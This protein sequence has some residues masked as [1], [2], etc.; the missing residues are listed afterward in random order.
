MSGLRTWQ[1]KRSR[2]LWFRQVR[3]PSVSLRHCDSPRLRVAG[4]ITG[5]RVLFLQHDPSKS[6][7]CAALR[8]G[9]TTIENSVSGSKHQ[10][11]FIAA[12][13]RNL[14]VAVKGDL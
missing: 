14:V 6:F 7:H 9:N 10:R 1:E 12:Q 3:L 5:A 2:T 4:K 8:I 11:Q 13:I